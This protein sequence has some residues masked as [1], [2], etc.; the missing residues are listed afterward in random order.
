MPYVGNKGEWAEIYVLLKLLADG[1][2]YQGDEH[3]NITDSFMSIL[4]IMR[5]EADNVLRYQRGSIHN[6]NYTD[7]SLIYVIKNERNDGSV[8]IEQL[9]ISAERMVAAIDGITNNNNSMPWLNDLLEQMQVQSLKA[10]SVDKCDIFLETLDNSGM[11]VNDGY[12]IKSQF[13]SGSTLFNYGEGSKLLCEVHNCTE[14]EMHRINAIMVSPKNGHEPTNDAVDVKGRLKYIFEHNDLSLKPIGFTHNDGTFEDS[15]ENIGIDVAE[16][17]SW[18]ILYHWNY[19]QDNTD[20]SAKLNDLIEK[21]SVNNPMNKRYP[22]DYYQNRLKEFAFCAFAGLTAT[23]YWDGTRV[24]NG[25]YIEVKRNGDILFYPARSDNQ[26]MSYLI[27]KLKIDDPSKG[28]YALEYSRKAYEYFGNGIPV[29]LNERIEDYYCKA[30]S[31]NK[32][33]SIYKK[34]DYGYVYYNETTDT[35]YMDINFSL[36]FIK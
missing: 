32:P 26:F 9:N 28:I 23:N 8:E 33:I 24:V 34:G 18:L 5:H 19:F 14:L 30:R 2:I 15:L 11:I 36:R 16:V 20:G 25:G 29:R 6:A 22:N 4:A 7:P 3:L 10:K 31:K 12:S 21:L 35:Y 1:R 17:L 13:G 27:Q